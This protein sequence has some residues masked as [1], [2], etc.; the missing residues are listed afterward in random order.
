MAKPALLSTQFLVFVTGGVLCALIDVGLMQGLLM[1]GAAPLTAASA[2]FLAGLLV[3]YL[4][5]AKVTFKQL[6]SGATVARYLCVV[7]INYLITLALVALAQ[8]WFGMAMIGKLA[9]LPVVAVNG[10]LLS[11]HWVFK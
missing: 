10:Y 1:G 5:H 9:S 2:G 6:S 11:K 8:H 7:A 3:N 4:F